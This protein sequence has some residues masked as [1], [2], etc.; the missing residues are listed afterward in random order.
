MT[1]NNSSLDFSKMQSTVCLTF[2]LKLHNDCFLNLNVHTHF[3]YLLTQPV[4]LQR[5]GRNI[6]LVALIKFK[7]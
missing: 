6:E 7:L 4:D 1:L 5:M 3:N 2:I